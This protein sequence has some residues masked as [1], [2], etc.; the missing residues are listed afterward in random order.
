MEILSEVAGERNGEEVEIRKV[1]EYRLCGLLRRRKCNMAVVV[2]VHRHYLEC[3][4]GIAAISTL[5]FWQMVE[6]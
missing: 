6:P 4:I 5:N 1:G 3:T 2:F